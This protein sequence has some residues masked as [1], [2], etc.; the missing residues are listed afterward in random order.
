VEDERGAIPSLDDSEELEETNVDLGLDLNPDDLCGSLVFEGEEAPG[1]PVREALATF[2]DTCVSKRIDKEHLKGLKNRPSNCP[3]VVVP[4]VTPAIW[5]ELDKFHRTR[6]VG[7]QSTQEL[8]V[9]ALQV[10]ISLKEGLAT[11]SPKSELSSQCNTIIALLGNASLETSFRRRELLRPSINKKFHSLCAPATP[12][13]K[14]LFGDKMTDELK[15]INEVARVAKGVM[16]SSARDDRPA[17]KRPFGGQGSRQS[18]SLNWNGRQN[19]DRR[20]QGHQGQRRV[21]RGG[22]ANNQLSDR[23]P[24]N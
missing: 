7:M 15:E 20:K 10:A 11:A 17:S 19:N 12:I 23:R 14:M 16:Q 21:T 9:R 13:G 24:R 18:Q 3:N 6:D 1:G 5:R 2:V 8:I 4:Q 22:R